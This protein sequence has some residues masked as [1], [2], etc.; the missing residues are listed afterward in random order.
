MPD[1][2][3]RL[4]AWGQPGPAVDAGE[5]YVQRPARRRPRGA[6]VDAAHVA[7]DVPGERPCSTGHDEHQS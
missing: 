5:Q 1:V 4:L 7:V 3:P 2:Q 6:G